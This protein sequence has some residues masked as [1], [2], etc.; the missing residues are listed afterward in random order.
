MKKFSFPRIIKFKSNRERLTVFAALATAVI[1]LITTFLIDPFLENQR[2]IREEIPMRTH[3]LTKYRQFVAGK[4]QAQQQ[5]RRIQE[6]SRIGQA[7]LLPGDTAS[8]AAA[9]LQEILKTLAAKHQINIKSEKVLDTKPLDFFDE[10]FVQIEFTTMITN[11]A[12][13]LYDIETYQKVLMVPDCSVSVNTYRG[14]RDV[15][16][17]IVV[18]GLMA[19]GKSTK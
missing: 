13:F 7:K 19:G 2:N 10:I 11:L 1:F 9:N 15:R 17:T 12:S 8:L 3:Q 4:N 5:L 6:T 16:A 14:P 18:S